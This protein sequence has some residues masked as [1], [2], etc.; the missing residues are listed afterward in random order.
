MPKPPSRGHSPSSSPYRCLRLLYRRNASTVIGYNLPVAMVVARAP[1]AINAK[2]C[3]H[4][5]MHHMTITFHTRKARQNSAHPC[6][7]SPP[8]P[9]LASSPSPN[10]HVWLSS[11]LGCTQAYRNFAAQEDRW[12][13]TKSA[14]K[15]KSMTFPLWKVTPDLDACHVKCSRNPTALLSSSGILAPL[16]ASFRHPP[17]HVRNSS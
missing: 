17:Q 5:G 7:E 14:R 15:P 8:R 4:C 1:L 16:S 3:A 12:Y 10:G 6:A 11:Q 13:R 9:Q 2:A